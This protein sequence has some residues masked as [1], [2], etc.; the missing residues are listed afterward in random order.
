MLRMPRTL[1]GE[2]VAL[3]YDEGVSLNQLV[4]STLAGLVARRAEAAGGAGEDAAA[5]RDGI[6]LVRRDLAELSA[7]TSERRDTDAGSPRSTPLSGARPSTSK[8]TTTRTTR[9]RKPLLGGS[10]SWPRSA[11]RFDLAL[12][13]LGQAPNDPE[14]PR[15]AELEA[16]FDAIPDLRGFTQACSPGSLRE[17]CEAF[18]LEAVY[19]KEREEVRLTVVLSAKAAAIAGL[20][21]EEPQRKDHLSGV[22]SIAGA[23][24]E[25]AAFGL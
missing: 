9:S 6:A 22:C 16:L 21:G 13:E 3:A 2:L 7:A 15:Q 5:L 17:L 14:P 24:F 19:D 11:R 4:V 25:P 8:R 12:A 1:H 10:K 23:G 20:L 18:E